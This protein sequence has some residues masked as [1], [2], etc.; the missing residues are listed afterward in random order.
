VSGEWLAILVG[1]LEGMVTSSVFVLVLLIGFCIVV[2]YLKLIKPD[3]SELVIR[4]LDE[5]IDH[6]PMRML[7]AT[8]P[9]G[10][11][12]QLRAPELLESKPRAA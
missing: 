2:G 8:T 10:E 6:K 3:G 1:F 12:D 11:A 4:S 7:P 9:R 5:A